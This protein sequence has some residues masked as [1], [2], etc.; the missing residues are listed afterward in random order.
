MQH[1]YDDY[2]DTRVSRPYGLSRAG[3]LFGLVIIFI[4]VADIVITIVDMYVT[5]F[6]QGQSQTVL[7]SVYT[8]DENPFWPSYGK[9]FW[10]GLVVNYIEHI[11]ST[12]I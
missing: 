10:V 4:G 2:Y 3:V 11:N 9:G 7:T 5:N 8:W 12:H 6:N 1:D